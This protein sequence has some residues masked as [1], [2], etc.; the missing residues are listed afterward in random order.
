MN[1]PQWPMAVVPFPKM[2]S[3]IVGFLAINFWWHTKATSPA[4]PKIKGTKIR[5]ELQGRTV[6]AS[7]IGRRKDVAEVR[8]RKIP[9]KST[10][11][12]LRPKVPS[13]VIK[14]R[15]K[16]ALVSEA[17]TSGILIQKIHLFNLH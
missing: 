15:N 12:N 6:P 10:R 11:F 5:E 16:A 17:M 13:G 4:N 2:E 1:V 9:M 14:R 7:V 3:L 8:N